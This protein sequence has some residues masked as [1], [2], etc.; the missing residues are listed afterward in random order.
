MCAVEA[1]RSLCFVLVARA[2][3]LAIEGELTS[4]YLPLKFLNLSFLRGPMKIEVWCILIPQSTGLPKPVFAMVV[5]VPC[6][7]SAFPQE[8]PNAEQ[9]HS[10]LFSDPFPHDVRIKS[11]FKNVLT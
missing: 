11:F 10:A 5:E 1:T 7:L 8:I 4:H 6:L 2:K 9:T 3:T